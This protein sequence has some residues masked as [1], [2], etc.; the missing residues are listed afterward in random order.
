MN[1]RRQAPAL[2]IATAIV[3]IL[4]ITGVAQLLTGR[5]LESAHEGDY[6]LMRQILADFINSTE[7][8]AVSR[9]EIVAAMPSVRAAFIARDRPK[10]LA[11][12]D[13]M[14]HVEEEK[15]GVDQAQFHTPPGVSFLRLHDPTKFGDDSST[16][17]PMLAEAHDTKLVRTGLEIASTGPAVFGIVPIFDEGGQLAGTFEMGLDFAP[18]LDRM[19]QAYGVEAALFFEEKLLK[20]HATNLPGDVVSG[21][22][23]VGRFIRFHSTHPE[24]VAELIDDRD[25]DVKQPKSY[26]REGSGR[27]W[28]VQLVPLYNYANEQIGVVALATSF[29]EDKR[30]AHRAQIW[31]ILAAVFGVLVFAGTTLIV[32][33]G[34]LLAPLAALTEKFSALAEGGQPPAANPVDSYCDELQTLAA[35]YERLR[36]GKP[37]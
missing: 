32:V 11:E 19:K 8:Q 37:S 20:E 21:K 26:E 1:F 13:K 6:A 28:G 36:T 25:V 10:L 22:N 15:Y 7:R 29:G 31:Q 18:K 30:L 3:V 34:F 9:A 5:L 24:L 14:F 27:S 4:A 23:R 2:L 12:C 17:R 16:D 33:R 35:S